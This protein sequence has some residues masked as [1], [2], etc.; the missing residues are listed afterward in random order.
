MIDTKNVKPVVKINHPF[1][2]LPLA[3]CKIHSNFK[4]R[5]SVSEKKVPLAEI[6]YNIIW[7]CIWK[8]AV[9]TPL[10]TA[11]NISWSFRYE[12]HVM[13]YFFSILQTQHLHSS[14]TIYEFIKLG[15]HIW[16]NLKK[17]QVCLRVINR[18]FSS[19]VKLYT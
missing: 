12:G 13:N 6:Y 15:R 4:V 5:K 2:E 10:P 16:F 17:F 9:L 18:I 3:K 1:L 14:C 19:L 8:S 7:S 11:I